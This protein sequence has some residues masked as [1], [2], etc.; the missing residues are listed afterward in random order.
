MQ[1]FEK[2]LKIQKLKP[3]HKC[4][5]NS[6][7]YSIWPPHTGM[8]MYPGPAPAGSRGSLGMMALAKRIA[9]GRDRGLI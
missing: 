9:K 2:K 5:G 3:N 4:V 6:N 7:Y 1:L 8:H